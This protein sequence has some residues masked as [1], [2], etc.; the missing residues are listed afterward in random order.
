MITSKTPSKLSQ[1]EQLRQS[2]DISDPI[3]MYVGNLESY[4]GIDLLLEGFARLIATGSCRASLVII[5]GDRSSI[6]AYSKVAA[7]LNIADAVYMVGPRPVE[8]LSDYLAQ[9]DILVSPR[10]KGVNTPMKLFS[11]LKSGKPT[12]VTNLVTHTQ[13]V[14]EKTALLIEPYAASLA[15]GLQTLLADKAL[16]QQLGRA[17]KQLVETSYS[18]DAFRRTFNSVM[19]WLESELQE[20]RGQQELAV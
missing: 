9:A 16:C 12:V 5:G 4:Q 18:Q 3:I 13:V 20:G 7:Q 15:A 6:E 8:K 19:S 1:T 2:F 11:Y 17:G 14:D 10:L